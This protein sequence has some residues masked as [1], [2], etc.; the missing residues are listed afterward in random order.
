MNN[1]EPYKI[2]VSD[3]VEIDGMEGLFVVIGYSVTKEI[4]FEG[5][6][7]EEFYIC[8]QKDKEYTI[9]ASES[10]LKLYKKGTFVPRKSIKQD[11]NF[12]YITFSLEED[13]DFD[14]FLDNVLEEELVKM[15]EEDPKAKI[16]QVRE[17][18]RKEDE[19]MRKN[20]QATEELEGKE[21]IDFMLDKYND[22]LTLSHDLKK[23]IP[24]LSKDFKKEANKVM[25][26]LKAFAKSQGGGTA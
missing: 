5:E 23:S 17:Q 14:S 20:E 16:Q 19:L 18:Q 1:N 13:E 6:F 3:E 2:K 12:T 7:E 21:L 15:G 26:E 8:Q 4:D 9:E 10:D 24:Q 11:S 22:L 25:K